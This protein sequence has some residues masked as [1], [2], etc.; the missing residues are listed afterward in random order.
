MPAQGLAEIVEEHSADADDH[1]I[2]ACP[3]PKR[4]RGP[5]LRSVEGLRS[6]Q[7]CVAASSG[8]SS[9]AGA[10]QRDQT[11]PLLVGLSRSRCCA[12]ID[13]VLVF[14]LLCLDLLRKSWPRRL[15]ELRLAVLGAELLGVEHRRADQLAVLD[16]LDRQLHAVVAGPAQQRLGRQVAGVIALAVDRP[17]ANSQPT[18]RPCTVLDRLRKHVGHHFHKISTH[19]RR[20]LT[21]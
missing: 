6:I 3:G 5:P 1:L 9:T 18:G 16:L 20:R 7:P 19:Y 8:A 11:S 13:P 15:L 14:G 21:S 17:F 2:P 12:A 10:P 4:R